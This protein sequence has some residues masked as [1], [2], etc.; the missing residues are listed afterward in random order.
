MENA[1]YVQDI[2]AG[3]T[4]ASVMFWTDVFLDEHIVM[5]PVLGVV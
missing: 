3:Y 5:F 1:A 4:Y 2:C